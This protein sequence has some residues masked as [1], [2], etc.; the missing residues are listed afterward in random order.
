MLESDHFILAQKSPVPPRQIFFVK[1]RIYGSIQLYHIITECFKN[2]A[3]DPVPTN[4]DLKTYS[5]PVIRNNGE[6]IDHGTT[7]FEM[8]TVK[9]FLKVRF[10]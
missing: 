4:M 6:I 5:F 9:N 10:G 8:N 2:A 7:F 3:D 1:A